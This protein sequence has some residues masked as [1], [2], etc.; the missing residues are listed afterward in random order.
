MKTFVILLS[1]TDLETDA[2]SIEKHVDYLKSL[3]DKGLLM[4]AGPFS[5]YPGGMVVIRAHHEEEAIQIALTDPFIALGY[6][7]FEVRTLEV[8]NKEN[9]YLL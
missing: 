3:D 2:T 4:L 5:D 8:A 1:N 9:H 6:R 7:T